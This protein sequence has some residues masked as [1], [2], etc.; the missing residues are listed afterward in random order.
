MPTKTK[1]SGASGAKKSGAYGAKKKTA[2]SSV[3]KKSGTGRRKGSS[4]SMFGVDPPIIVDGGG[5]VLIYSMV[6]LT[7]TTSIPKY[8]FAYRIDV[9]I[10]EMDWD[11]KNHKSDKTKNGKDFKLELWD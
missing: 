5:S 6:D 8:P 11:G 10:A 3:V 9:D 2:K 7:P 1:K 4:V